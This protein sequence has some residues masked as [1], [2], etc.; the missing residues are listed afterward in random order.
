[1]KGVKEKNLVKWE[2]RNDFVKKL[3]EADCAVREK[4]GFIDPAL[5]APRAQSAFKKRFGVGLNSQRMYTIRRGVFK[6]HDLDERGRPLPGRVKRLPGVPTLQAGS[7]PGLT[8]ANRDPSDPMFHVAVVPIADETQGAFLK[9][10]LEKLS[11][12]GLVDKTLRVDGI[13]AH[14]ATV[15]KFPE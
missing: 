15:S 13:H 7:G 5:S 4:E 9:Q 14:Y 1:M 6:E 10:A 3:F 2:E 12:R 8:A 11:E